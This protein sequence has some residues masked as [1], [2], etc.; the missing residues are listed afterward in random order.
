VTN[1]PR[2]KATSDD[3]ILVQVVRS[4]RT[5]SNQRKGDEVGSLEEDAAVGAVMAGTRLSIKK[6][7][8]SWMTGGST[9]TRMMVGSEIERNWMKIRARKS[10]EAVQEL[11]KITTSAITHLGKC[12]L[13][14][15]GP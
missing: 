9:L 3:V 13:T 10:S 5:T 4:V 6:P 1:V 15:I 12:N 2:G 7:K 11:A 14:S 8:R